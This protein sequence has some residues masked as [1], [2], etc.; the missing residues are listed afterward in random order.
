MLE[1]VT[2]RMPAI[3]TVI[4]EMRLAVNVRVPVAKPG[5]AM[6][7]IIVQP[8]IVQIVMHRNGCKQVIAMSAQIQYI[9]AP[10]IKI[11]LPL[12]VIV[13]KLFVQNCLIWV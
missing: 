3:V 7:Q 9:I 1:I 8:S 2:M 12:I 13:Q 4:A 5:S 11:V 6:P 10:V